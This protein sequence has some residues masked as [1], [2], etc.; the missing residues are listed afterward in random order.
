MGVTSFASKQSELDV[1]TPC[2]GRGI[3]DTAC[4]HTVLSV[5]KRGETRSSRPCLNR[6]NTDKGESVS[7]LQA[8][9]CLGVL[10]EGYLPD[11]GV[12]VLTRGQIDDEY[13]IV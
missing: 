11:A 8:A 10:F 3:L 7:P 2:T 1:E 6:C 5:A 4:W 9:R 12:M 13:W